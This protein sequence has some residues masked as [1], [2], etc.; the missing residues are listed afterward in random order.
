MQQLTWLAVT[1][2]AATSVI[3]LAIALA[4]VVAYIGLPINQFPQVQFRVVTIVTIYPGAKPQEIETQI[5][6]PIEDAVASL[7]NLDFTTSTS[8][9]GFSTVVVQFKDAADP[10]F[11][12]TDVERRVN[13]VAGGFPSGVS[14][15][16]VQKID[17]SQAPVMQLALVDAGLAPEVLYERVRTEV[18]PVLERAQGVS[19]VEIVGGRKPEIHVAVDP[20]RLAAYG[21]TLG[22]VQQ[23]LAGGNASLPG[24]GVTRGGQ[25][26]ELQVNGLLQRPE[27][28]GELVV[29]GSAGHP[30][31]V[32]DLATVREEPAALTQIARVNGEQALLIAIAQASGA[33]LTDVT[34]AV[35]AQIPKLEAQLPASSHLVV[36]SDRTPFV[37]GS[38]DGIKQEL[39]IAIL[40]DHGR[41]GQKLGRIEPPRREAIEERL[42]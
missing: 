38:L 3:F 15:P 37:R 35:R 7:P 39:L 42:R 26:F 31:R 19:Q 18:L 22:Q 27:D 34:D 23:A 16:I 17:L 8:S 32:R 10:A 41:P 2:R 14:T 33:N 12:G 24:G 20:E 13:T 4:G 1:R 9:E 28:I 36:V 11:I 21:V 29:G 40:A 6:S 25:L 5:S 30:V